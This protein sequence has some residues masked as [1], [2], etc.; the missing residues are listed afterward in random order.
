MQGVHPK[1]AAASGGSIYGIAL[2]DLIVWALGLAHIA[3]PA[4]VS[5]DLT[6]LLGGTVAFVAG[7]LTKNPSTPATGPG[8]A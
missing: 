6:I 4:N 3:V 5:S 1:V 2:A 8:K 7:Y